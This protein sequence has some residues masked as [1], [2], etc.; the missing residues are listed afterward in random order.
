MK[1]W[2]CLNFTSVAIV[3]SAMKKEMWLFGKSFGTKQTPANS[4]LARTSLTSSS[5][6]GLTVICRRSESHTPAGPSF[7]SLNLFSLKCQFIMSPNLPGFLLDI[8]R[9]PIAAVGLPLILGFLSGA[10]TKK[11]INSVWYQVRPLASEV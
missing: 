7:P 6:Q 11:V 4:K 9:N 3:C 8:P 2:G 10:R 5:I 1:G